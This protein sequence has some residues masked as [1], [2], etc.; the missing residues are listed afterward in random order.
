MSTLLPRDNASLAII[1][2]RIAVS[3]FC[4][5][6]VIQIG[7]AVG[8]L[9][10]TIVWGGSQHARTW[11]NSVASV[12]AA[13]ILLGMAGIVH[14]RATV[15]VPSLPLRVAAWIVAG[16]MMLNTLGNFLS[17][18]WVE[19]YIFGTMTVVLAICSAVVASSST[20]TSFSSV[21]VDNVQRTN[22]QSIS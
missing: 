11:Q 22:Y 10:V 5:M 12:V 13:V 4:L 14:F 1:A 15:A 2:S 17:P 9:P 7:I 19:R 16:Y 6:A 18:S 3:L 20:V 21:P 8:L